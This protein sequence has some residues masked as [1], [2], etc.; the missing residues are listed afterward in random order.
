[1]YYP[2]G[3]T[4]GQQWCKHYYTPWTTARDLDGVT[5]VE[6]R[7]GHCGHTYSVKYEP[8]YRLTNGTAGL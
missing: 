3:S 2:W 5:F 4:N 7:C 6:Y 8:M 1:V